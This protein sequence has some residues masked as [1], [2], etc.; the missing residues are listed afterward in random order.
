M[1][2]VADV[3]SIEI[4]AVFSFLVTVFVGADVLGVVAAA[5]IFNGSEFLHSVAEGDSV[6]GV[7]LGSGTSYGWRHKVEVGSRV[8]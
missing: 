4:E 6:C 8:V 1:F 3:E 2:V 7:E 5:L